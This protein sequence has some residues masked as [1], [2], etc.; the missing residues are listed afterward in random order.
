MCH[1]FLPVSAVAVLCSVI[2][3]SEQPVKSAVI[4]EQTTFQL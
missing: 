4:S 2:R 3:E 1:N